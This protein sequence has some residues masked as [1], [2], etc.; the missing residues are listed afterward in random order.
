MP[1]L[2][3]VSIATTDTSHFSWTAIGATPD[4]AREAL[5]DGWR[6]HAEEYGCD[7]EYVTA[8][9]INVITGPVGQAWR[10]QSPLLH[11]PCPVGAAAQ[12]TGDA[13]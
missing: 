12:G 3:L 1:D 6:A 8:D 4:E 9:S 11:L 5:L 13:R 7:P 2:A 10:D